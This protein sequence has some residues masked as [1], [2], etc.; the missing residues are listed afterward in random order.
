MPLRQA[1]PQHRLHRWWRLLSPCMPYKLFDPLTGFCRR[2]RKCNA[3]AITHA[4]TNCGQTAM[5]EP[6]DYDI[7]QI[8]VGGARC[9]LTQRLK[10]KK[11]KEKLVFKLL[12]FKRCF[13]LQLKFK[14]EKLLLNFIKNRFRLKVLNLKASHCVKN[15]SVN[16]LPNVARRR[17]KTKSNEDPFLSSFSAVCKANHCRHNSMAALQ[18]GHVRER[19]NAG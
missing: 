9:K 14:S 1:L 7:V 2:S 4:S 10:A 15:L 16:L 8:N 3:G 5:S 11:E 19:E 6:I 13:Q 18:V 12:K 17:G